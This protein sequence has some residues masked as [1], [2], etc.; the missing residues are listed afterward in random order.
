MTDKTNGYIRLLNY[1]ISAEK[2]SKYWKSNGCSKISIRNIRKI[3][4]TQTKGRVT[5]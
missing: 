4:I 3:S 1:I 5:V 2:E